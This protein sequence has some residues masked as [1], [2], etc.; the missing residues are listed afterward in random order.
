MEC[1]GWDCWKLASAS[2]RRATRPRI[3]PRRSYSAASA[4]PMPLD[5]PVMKTFMALLIPAPQVLHLLRA[6]LGD[7]VVE[8][9]D[10]ARQA[11]RRSRTRFILALHSQRW[12]AVDLVVVQQLLVALDL[13]LRRE[14]VVRGQV[15]LRIDT[16]LGEE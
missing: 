6:N 15:L 7:E 14:R 10:R 1:W 11:V 2:P 12:H 9:L 13:A 3:A 8:H 5:A 16:V 4:R